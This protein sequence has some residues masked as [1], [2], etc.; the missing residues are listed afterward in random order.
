MNP[1]PL[2]KE[3]IF[4][5]G[6]LALAICLP[7]VANAVG[8]S[9]ADPDPANGTYET[10]DTAVVMKGSAT[11]TPFQLEQIV[12]END[13]TSDAGFAKGSTS[14][15]TNWSW[16]ADVLLDIGINNITVTA[17]DV[18]GVTASGVVT[19]KRMQQTL[20]PPSED[21]P[22]LIGDSKVKFTVLTGYTGPSSP[23]E[24]GGD[25]AS[26]VTYFD[27]EGFE[28]PFSEDV[29]VV[30]SIRDPNDPN[31]DREAF[32]QL[33]PAG[34]VPLGQ[35]YTYSS[36]PGGIR[37]LWFRPASGGRIQAYFYVEGR[38]KNA[39]TQVD[40]FPEVRDYFL[41]NTYQG[42]SYPANYGQWLTEVQLMDVS[43]QVGDTL[44]S[45]TM[46][47]DGF[48]QRPNPAEPKSVQLLY[49]R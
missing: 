18:F 8:I 22:L 5:A 27:A 19:V 25:T 33:I 40:F 23:I 42:L 43:I 21:V 3:S 45:G 35:K 2:P 1:V 11:A 12:W 41:A 38:P 28:M 16:E 15:W 24:A 36:G 26:V 10:T 14:N 37:N 47:F 13:A 39:S 48:I 6:C 31:L 34:S 30:F 4:A 49:N 20:P 17:T 9:I 29:L 7:G 32:R 44:Y 46:P